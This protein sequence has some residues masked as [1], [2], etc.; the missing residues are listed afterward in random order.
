[1]RLIGRAM[2]VPGRLAPHGSLMVARRW[3]CNEKNLKGLPELPVTAV[4]ITAAPT[5]WRSKLRVYAELG[6]SVTCTICCGD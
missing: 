5:D 2:L 6:E 4:P 1:M 3:D